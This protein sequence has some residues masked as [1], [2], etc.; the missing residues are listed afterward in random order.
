MVFLHPR[1]HRQHRNSRP[2]VIV[3]D[4][5]GQRPEVRGSPEEHHREHIQRGQI[6]QPNRAPGYREPSHHRR[7]RPG[8][9]AYHDVLRSAPL[10]SL[11]INEDVEERRRQCEQRAQN[12]HERAQ[13]DESHYVQRDSEPHSVMRRDAAA[14][15][16][17]VPR[18]VPSVHQYRGPDSG[19]ARSRH[20][21]PALRRPVQE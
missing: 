1:D 17:D 8:C 16:R 21:P 12:V 19:S 2:P 5:Q 11:R 15:N 10:Q 14:D 6:R 20:R 9:A 4:H 13:N 18:C 3:L 7:Y